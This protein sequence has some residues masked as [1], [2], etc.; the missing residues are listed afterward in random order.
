MLNSLRIKIQDR[1]FKDQYFSEFETLPQVEFAPPPSHIDADISLVWAMSSAKQIRKNP[2]DIA[3]KAAKIIE[4]L[5]EVA[6][7]GFLAPS[8]CV[9]KQEHQKQ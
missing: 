2:L 1:L 4:Q 9:D 8:G 7:C 6:Q 5:E 3:K